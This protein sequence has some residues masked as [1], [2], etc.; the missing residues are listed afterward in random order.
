MTKTIQQNEQA[1]MKR[2][3]TIMKIAL[4]VAFVLTALA[5]KLAK[6]KKPVE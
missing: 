2:G 6:N 3:Q 4:V 1:S 5:N